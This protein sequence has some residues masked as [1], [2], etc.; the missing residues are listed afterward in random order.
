MHQG[1]KHILSHAAIYLIARGLPGIVAFVAI[2]LFTRLLE[3]A[4]YGRYALVIATVS[5]LNALLFQWIRLSLIRYLP[6]YKDDPAR[7]KSS[8][9]S[10]TVV[11]FAALGV[12]A[13]VTSLLPVARGWVT[14][15]M[16][17]WVVLGVQ[18]AFE[19]CSEYARGMIRPWQYMALQL[20]RSAAG[21]ALGGGLVV[22]GLGWWGPVAGMAA[23]M[24][25]AVAWVYRR[26]WSDV[27]FLL[28]RQTLLRVAQYGVPLSMTVALTV[29]VSS[30]DRFLIAWFLG[31]DAAGLYSVAVDFTSQ[32]LTLLMMAIYMAV[33]PLAVQAWEHHGREA[34]QAQMRFNAALLMAVG[35]PCVV[36]LTVLAPGVT[37][38]F[39]G[40]SFRSTAA[41]I[42]PMVAMG[43]FLAGLKCCHFD[44]AFQFAHRTIYQV[45]I[46]LFVAVINIVF[47]LIAVPRWGI[48]G[49]AVASVLAYLISIVL[50]AWIGRRHFILPFPLSSCGQ[51]LLAGGI[52]GA[53]LYPLRA[54][55]SPSAVIMEIAAGA[56]VYGLI[57]LA[58][59]F[60]GLRESFINKYSGSK[61][62][63]PNLVGPSNIADD[64][65]AALAQG[66]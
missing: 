8:L 19:L 21:V 37:S 38:C 1:R 22:M 58:S 41:G 64:L 45:W 48:N 43:T 63:E 50:T 7:L 29:V 27:R 5:M 26:D 14:I 54:H 16:T 44:T 3:P 31:E 60:L 33:F 9:V 51:V 13:C 59:N 52:M 36:G 20:A 39:L 4:D 53:V 65:A 10:A 11:L 49:A 28:D 12:I 17:C 18:A 32:T 47:N 15:I 61:P 23:G 30:S 66:R 56:A 2:P 62:A 25:I 55:T 35:V 40:S 57:L 34:A 24:A 42:M 6:A 46:V